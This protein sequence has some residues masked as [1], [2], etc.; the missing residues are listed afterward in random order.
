MEE[1]EGFI[2][3]S[4]AAIKGVFN[5]VFGSVVYEILIVMLISFIL[6]F[7]VSAKN[8]GASQS[9][10]QTLVDAAYD[11]FP[12]SILISCLSSLVTLVVFVIILKKETFMRLLKNAF[13]LDTLK[14]GAITAACLMAFSIVYNNLAIILFE[15]EDGGN[16][17]Q[18]AVTV[19][20][21]SNPFLGL[22]AVVILAP[23]VEELTFRYCLFGEV[24]KKN[25]VFAY[26]IS[27][28]VFMAMHSIASI[29]EAGGLNK[30]FLQELIYLP[31]YLFSGLALCYV[32]DKTSN[33]GSSV[34]AHML[35]NLV[36]FLVIVFL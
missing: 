14:Y 3:D 32:Y 26:V 12:F 21:K 27:G 9:E 19:L 30:A 1:R 35:N 16:A 28:V 13:S 6:T 22:L 11:S 23:V 17:N 10:L 24:S 34:M 33:I 31:P 36:S 7:A 20:V 25:K 15:L 18:E 5:G 29:S 2:K 4:K 8:P